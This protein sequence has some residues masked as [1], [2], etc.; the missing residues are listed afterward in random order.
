MQSYCLDWLPASFCELTVS[1]CP[2]GLTCSC[3]KTNEFLNCFVTR[4]PITSRC[5]RALS[6]LA[7]RHCSRSP[8]FNPPFFPSL[9]YTLQGV[10]AEPAYPLPNILMQFIQ[11]NNLIK[12]T[13]MFNVLQ[14]SARMQTS[15]TVGRIDAI[16]YRPC[17]ASRMALKRGGAC[18]FGPPHWQ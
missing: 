18:T 5:T 16:D 4:E 11:T 14:K 1:Q 12:S 6:T 9:W 7:I 15:A 13:L 17:I 2:A 8:F 3:K 10:W